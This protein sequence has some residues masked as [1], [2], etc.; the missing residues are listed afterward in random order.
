MPN[1]KMKDLSE[2]ERIK[3]RDSFITIDEFIKEY[4][5]QLHPKT[6]GRWYKVSKDIMELVPLIATS[7]HALYQYSNEELRKAQGPDPFD[8]LRGI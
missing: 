4:L 1:N 7:G 8:P 5:W 3:L 2:E 6:S